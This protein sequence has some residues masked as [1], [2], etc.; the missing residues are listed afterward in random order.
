VKGT[1]W[2]YR[3]SWDERETVFT[4][5]AK[6]VE[7]KDKKTFGRVD[8]LLSSSQRL[9][10]DLYTDDTGVYRTGF[11]GAKLNQPLAVIKY[12]FKARDVWK[13]KINVGEIQG[14]VVITVKDVAAAVQVPAGK[15][16]ALAVE[17]VVEMN[18]EKVVASIWY[19]NGV[20]IVKQETTSSSKTVI[21]ELTKFTPAK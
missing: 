19:A 17:S 2:D 11:L 20:G 10:E 16:T 3:L 8:A 15:F 12:P 14:T 21:M 9:G 13:D 7:T 18:G 1:K 4:C 5:E 6:E